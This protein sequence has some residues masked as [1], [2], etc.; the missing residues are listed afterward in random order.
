MKNKKRIA[1]WGTRLS[2]NF[3]TLI[4]T[5]LFFWFL[6]FI[7]KD[8]RSL[9]GPDYQAST[10]SFFDPKLRSESEELKR[11]IAVLRGSITKKEQQQKILREGSSD[12]EKTLDRLKESGVEDDAKAKELASTAWQQLLE[13]R[14]QIMTLGNEV[15][16]ANADMVKLESRKSDIDAKLSVQDQSAREHYSKLYNRHRL[17]TAFYQIG[18]LSP[19]FLAS[20]F[21]LLRRRG[22]PYFPVY[23]A[24]GLATFF[25]IGF[26]MF[27]YFPREYFKYILIGFLIVAILWLLICTIRSVAK[28]T[29]DRVMKQNRESYERFLCTTCEYPIRTGPRT[30]LYWTR[31]TVHKILPKGDATDEE[32][33]LCPHC[34]TSLYEACSACGKVRHA[35]L[36]YCHHCGNKKEI[37]TTEA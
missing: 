18:A 28:P 23:L 27:E 13:R 32:T 1:S 9:P 15:V 16:D 37:E 3:F 33:Y 4:L 24:L 25:Q 26:V 35:Q 12:L 2:I 19:F 20:V 5:I 11:E 30:F 14:Q 17:L 29:F 21:F 8:L 36:E 34:G 22:S 10:A 31:R 7:L 6:G